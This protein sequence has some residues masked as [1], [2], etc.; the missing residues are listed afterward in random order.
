MYAS[1]LTIVRK[2]KQ[3]VLLCFGVF[4]EKVAI[5]VVFQLKVGS[6]DSFLGWRIEQ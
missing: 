3:N 2:K 6:L 4:Y 1:L 5:Q